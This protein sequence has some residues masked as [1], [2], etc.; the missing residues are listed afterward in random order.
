MT[1]SP[2]A[3]RYR[4]V[5]AALVVLA[6]LGTGRDGA[7]LADVLTGDAVVLARMRAAAA[8]MRAVPLP[9]E[10][11][12][13]P[14]LGDPADPLGPSELVAAADR[15]SRYA[16][17][18]VAEL[19]RACALDIARGL[20]RMWEGCRGM[21]PLGDPTRRLQLR[22]TRI[23][24]LS[25]VR[26]R[27]T[28]LR[29]ELREEIARLSLRRAR[30]FPEYVERRL[31]AVAAEMT[32]A[33]DWEWPG[34]AVELPVGTVPPPGPTEARSGT[35]LAAAFGLG[36]ALTLGRALAGL[37]PACPGAAAAAGV[38]IG[39]ALAGWVLA[40]R[41]LLARRAVLDRWVSEVVGGLRA[42]LE[43]RIAMRALLTEAR[44]TGGLRR[45]GDEPGRVA[46]VP[47]I[48]DRLHTGAN[49]QVRDGSI[50]RAGRNAVVPSGIT[51]AGE[52]E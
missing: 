24:L 32:A 28:A 39:A 12:D 36:L 33:V 9:A 2:V 31:D 38:V 52:T 1:D 44:E 25:M 16:R 3:V 18:P 49:V 13:L 50:V 30:A 15:W 35:L 27:T 26:T 7:R 8:V 45:F 23:G 37:V 29:S 17:S 10:M 41:R 6:E 34:P 22:K 43:E 21:H 48:S 19:H 40:T 47:A 14:G 46:G 20:M 4:R 42:G 5:C 11:T 51:Q